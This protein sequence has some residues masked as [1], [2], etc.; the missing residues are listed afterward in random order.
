MG[1]AGSAEKRLVAVEVGKLHHSGYIT[2]PSDEPVA[3]TLT[4]EMLNH[5]AEGV[6]KSKMSV[7]K[8]YILGNVT[9]DEAWGVV[10]RLSDA[11]IPVEN[12]SL[13]IT[14]YGWPVHLIVQLNYR[15][16]KAPAHVFPETTVYTHPGVSTR[17]YTDLLSKEATV[18]IVSLDFYDDTAL[19]K[20]TKTPSKRMIF[21][22][23]TTDGF[24]KKVRAELEGL[25]IEIVDMTIP[26]GQPTPVSWMVVLD[27]GVA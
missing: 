22:C 19:N 27:H 25:P 16:P 4:A 24:I 20:I 13:S 12:V 23:K 11:Y 17:A 3:W 8:R 5:M 9:Q 1:A 6:A 14:P 21:V 7:E 15:R 18:N 26:L 2:P 10:T